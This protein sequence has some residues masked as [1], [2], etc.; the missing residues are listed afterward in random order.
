MM[1]EVKWWESLTENL[2]IRLYY[3]WFLTNIQRKVHG[4]SQ[5]FADSTGCFPQHSHT[6][7]D[8]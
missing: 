6:G 4:A 1:R 2:K 3:N 5:L 8:V 7:A